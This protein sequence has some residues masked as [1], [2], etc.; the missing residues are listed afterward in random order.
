MASTSEYEAA[1]KICRRNALKDKMERGEL[2][3]SFGLGTVLN[4]EIALMARTAGYD[5]ILMNL[6]HSRTG[7]E[8]ASD[9]ACACLNVGCVWPTIANITPIV[10]PS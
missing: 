10:E 7:L 4:P 8:T 1:S 2:A 6:E 9:I 3:Y 5:A